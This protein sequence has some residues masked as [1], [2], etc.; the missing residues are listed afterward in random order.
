MSARLMSWLCVATLAVVS[1]NG[2]GDALDDV[3]YRALATQLGASLPTGVTVRIDQVEAPTGGGESD[4][5]YRADPANVGFDGVTF[6]D[7]TAGSN[8]LFSGHATGVALQ[9]AGSASMTPGVP[10]VDSYEVNDWL[11]TVLYGDGLGPQRPA[12]GTGTLANHSWVGSTLDAAQAVDLLQRL[13]W[14]IDTDDTL[15]VVG[16]TTA[17]NPLFSHAYNVLGVT[18]TSVTT[19]A[20][21]A[22]LDVFYGA[23]RALAHVVAPRATPSEATAMVTSAA[24]LLRDAA[25]G[26]TLPPEV[27]KALLMAGADRITR[28]TA[29][30]NL[31]APLPLTANGLDPRYGAGQINVLNSHHLLAGGEIASVEDGGVTAR[32]TGYDYDL[33]FGGAQGANTEAH[34]PLGVITHAGR[35][36]A[37]LAW[38]ARI[39]DAGG[40][41]AP[42]GPEDRVVHDLNLELV[43]TTPTGDI[44][45]AASL[46]TL[47]NTETVT[48]DLHAG[49][50]YALLVRVQGPA[51]ARDYALAWRLEADQ[52]GDGVF[53]RFETGACP[54]AT[55]ADSDD[56]GLADGSE[57]TDLDGVLDDTETD[58]CNADTDEDGLADGLERGLTAGVPD[59]DGEGPLT[60]TAPEAFMPDSDP[61]SMSDPRLAD[62]DGDG[63][64]DGVEDANRNGALDPGESDPT[65][66]MSQPA[67]PEVIPALPPLAM[68]LL[69]LLIVT[70]AR[71]RVT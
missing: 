49:G 3:G 33:A 23:N 43:E 48:A 34:Y 12:P 67:D 16:V 64:A 56:D 30:G 37:T 8:P 13:D 59:P 5:I 31:A 53:D 70:A 63:H 25:P 35:L 46:S 4:P 58:P 18:R 32:D 50:Q 27:L 24:A 62:T 60:G 15:Q 6:H 10:D 22:P 9:F 17:A 1:V 65:D 42:T 40:V 19:P 57:D 38:H 39:V 45:R 36:Y 66:P 41:F 61:A 44:I 26:H 51:L 55:D 71:R 7:Q 14:L 68:G 28:N 69:A 20:L 11:G 2:R 52:D 54:D 47:D 29:T 21:T